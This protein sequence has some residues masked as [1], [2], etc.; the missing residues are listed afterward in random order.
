[1]RL[2]QPLPVQMLLPYQ[3]RV[4]TLWLREGFA[5]LHQVASIKWALPPLLHVW[6]PE[7]VELAQTEYQLPRL[8][9]MWTHLDRVGGGGAVKGTGTGVGAMCVRWGHGGCAHMGQARRHS[10]RTL[11]SAG[12]V[13]GRWCLKGLRGRC[14]DTC[15]CR[16]SARTLV[17]AG[18]VSEGAVSAGAV[19]EHSAVCGREEARDV[20]EPGRGCACAFLSGWMQLQA[21]AKDAGRGP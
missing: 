3:M 9:R 18:A 10:A 19:Q 14:K 17:S 21:L 15:V 1:V 13:Q 7:Q 20:L 4:H 16:R 6:L 11:V 5:A 2:Y 8:T 12:A